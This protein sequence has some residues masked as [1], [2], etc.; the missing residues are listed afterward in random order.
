M[1]KALLAVG[2]VKKLKNVSIDVGAQELQIERVH[3]TAILFVSIFYFLC[4]LQSFNIFF[5]L[6]NVHHINTQQ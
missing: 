5:N 2:R 6:S 3:N 1:S 4:L